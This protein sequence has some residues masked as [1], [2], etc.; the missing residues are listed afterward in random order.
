MNRSRW[1]A[2]DSA[3][4]NVLSRRPPGRTL[5]RA[6]R[7][8]D[9][10]SALAP[11]HSTRP[12]SLRSIMRRPRSALLITLLPPTPPDGRRA[13]AQRC[14]AL[15]RPVRR[16]VGRPAQRLLG[17]LRRQVVEGASDSGNEASWGPETS[18]GRDMPAP[19]QAER[20]RRVE[21]AAAWHERQKIADSGRRRS[22]PWRS[23]AGLHAARQRV[24]P[25]RRRAG[26]PLTTTIGHLQYIGV[27]RCTVWSSAGTSGTATSTPSISIKGGLDCPTATTTT[28]P[29]DHAVLGASTSPTSAACQLLGDDSARAASNAATVMAIETGSPPHRVAGRPR[30]R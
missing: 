1:R 11:F 17:V 6:A 9:T 28:T 23:R 19:P 30:D 29:T 27:A 13:S 21:S 22:I 16:P 8:A 10:S 18:S 20:E 15:P 2:S 5:R 25:H 4:Q 12:S 7:R 24:R 26:R 14:R 3:R